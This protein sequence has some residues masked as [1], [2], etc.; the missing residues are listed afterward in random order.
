MGGGGHVIN[1]LFSVL[2]NDLCYIYSEFENKCN[3]LNLSLFSLQ[4]CKK[5]I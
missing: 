5:N 2:L 4:A 1:D 3:V